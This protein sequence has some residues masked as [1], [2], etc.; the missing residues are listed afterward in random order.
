MSHVVTSPHY[1][2]NIFDVRNMLTDLETLKVEEDVVSKT[3]STA[4]GSKSL[5]GKHV[6]SAQKLKSVQELKWQQSN[7]DGQSVDSN[8]DAMRADRSVKFKLV[9]KVTYNTDS[10]FVII[11]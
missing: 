10:H 6:K 11:T 4:K 3:H 1:P 9:Y 2:K 8:D 5:V 7:K